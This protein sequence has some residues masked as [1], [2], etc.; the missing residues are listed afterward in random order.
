MQAALQLVSEE[1]FDQ[2]MAPRTSAAQIKEYFKLY[3]GE[4]EMTVCKKCCTIR[5]QASW[6]LDVP[7]MAQKVGEPYR[8]HFLLGYT[9]PTMLIHATLASAFNGMEQGESP[10]HD[11]ITLMVATDIFV[12]VLRSQNALFSIRLEAT[13]ESCAQQFPGVWPELYGGVGTVNS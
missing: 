9:I 11:D 13:L 8:K 7:S 3:K 2:E 6:D 4:F 10:E 5:P 12:K 1:V